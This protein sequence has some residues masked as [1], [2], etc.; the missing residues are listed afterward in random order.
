MIYQNEHLDWL[1]IEVP[2]YIYDETADVLSLDF[3]SQDLSEYDCSMYELNNYWVNAMIE[4]DEGIVPD[5]N[6]RN[7]GFRLKIL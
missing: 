7:E 3:D 5:P 1:S 4:I 2:D 6:Y